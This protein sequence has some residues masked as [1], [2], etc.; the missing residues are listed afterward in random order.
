MSLRWDDIR[1]AFAHDE[2]WFCDVLVPSPPGTLQ[3]LLD[4]VRR[5]GWAYKYTEDGTD[6]RLPTYAQI[7]QVREHR[8]PILT[9]WPGKTLPLNVHFFADDAVEATFDPRDLLG[10][11]ELD[12]LLQCLRVLGRHFGCDVSVTV[13]SQPK[14]V[15]LRYD[16]ASDGVVHV[17]PP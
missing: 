4:V 5:Q 8:A 16:A 3:G 13:E 9:F 17:P 1:D 2:G 15:M 7:K 11:Q 6:R 12:A 14:M 10:P